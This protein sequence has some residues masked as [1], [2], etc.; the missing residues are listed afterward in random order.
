MRVGLVLARISD[1]P[2]LSTHKGTNRTQVILI[3][4]AVQL[5]MF[6]TRDYN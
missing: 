3:V 2:N 6:D 1:R 4:M 5:A